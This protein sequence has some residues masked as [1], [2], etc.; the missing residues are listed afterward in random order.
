[1]AALANQRNSLTIL[2]ESPEG[3]YYGEE[4]MD[5]MGY[6]QYDEMGGHSGQYMDMYGEEDP[7]GN[8]DGQNV[9]RWQLR[10]HSLDRTKTTPRDR[11]ISRPT[12]DTLIGHF[13]IQIERLEEMCCRPSIILGEILIYLTWSMTSTATTQPTNM[14]STFFRMWQT[15]SNLRSY[16][17]SIT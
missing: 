13:S 1:M 10:T 3:Q 15:T 17:R 9:S 2:T 14:P 11:I 16:A 6:N 5:Q 12:S 7:Y 8:E 4:D